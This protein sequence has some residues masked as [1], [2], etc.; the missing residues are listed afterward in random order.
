[1]IPKLNVA[2]L[3]LSEIIPGTEGAP[4]NQEQSMPEPKQPT[5]KQPGLA[6]PKLNVEGL[7]LSELKAD[8]PKQQ[9]GVLDSS[10]S[11]DDFFKPPQG[12]S[13]MQPPQPKKPLGFSIPKL[14]VNGLGLSELIPGTEGPKIEDQQAA[15]PPQ[16]PIKKP[17][18]IPKLKVEGLGLSE[19]VPGTGDPAKDHPKEMIS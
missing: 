1:M 16:L 17:F 3:G 6:I 15:A 7:G 8:T 9:K 18:S 2:G 14:N 12:A 13:H 19:I 5:P 10:S 4:Q 11:D